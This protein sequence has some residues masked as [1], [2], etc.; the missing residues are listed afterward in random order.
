VGLE[1]PTASPLQFETGFESGRGAFINPEAFTPPEGLSYAGVSIP[2]LK[3][4]LTDERRTTLAKA[5]IFRTQSLEIQK[6]QLQ[7]LSQTIW[8]DYV[9]WYIAHEQEKAY[10]LGM[11]LSLDR[12]IALRQLFEA[13]G[14][15][16][17]DTL[18]NYIQ[19]ELF[20]TRAKEWN[21]N[22]YK[23]RLQLSRHLWEISGEE[24]SWKGVVIAENI[25]P[26]SAGLDFLDS[27]FVQTAVESIVLGF[28]TDIK[29]IDL[30]TEEGYDPAGFKL[31]TREVME[32]SLGETLIQSLQDKKLPTFKNPD[33]QMISG[34]ITTMTKYMAI[35]LETQ[36]TFIVEQVMNVL[37]TKIPSEEDFKK[38]ILKF[39]NSSD[40]P[41]QWAV[42]LSKKIIEN[43]SQE[44]I[45][46]LYDD[47]LMKVSI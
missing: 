6:I 38:K 13:G 36:R 27:L 4:L 30:D 18:E 41:K 25:L 14:C 10:R 31:Q 5:K 43:Y 16:G 12:Q 28:L 19:L 23:Q 26:T 34:I 44:K 22:T 15:N 9:D 40:V 33:M 24:G 20:R 46:V 39:R 42:D 45:N 1:L 11:M 17:M 32:K 37:M 29:N 21:A 35:D 3:G 7:D 8:G 2:L 47:F